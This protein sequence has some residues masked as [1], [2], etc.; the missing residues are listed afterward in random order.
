[1]VGFIDIEF[2]TNKSISNMRSDYTL[3]GSKF[4]KYSSILGIIPLIAKLFG[5]FSCQCSM[6][7]LIC[8]CT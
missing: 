8:V 1:M 7:L 4:T 2:S 6:F 3:A 5:G